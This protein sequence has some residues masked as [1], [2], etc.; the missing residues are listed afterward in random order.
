MLVT[1]ITGSGKSMLLRSLVVQALRHDMQL[2]ISDLDGMTFPIS[3]SHPALL[4]PIAQSSQAAH[5]L[6]QRV[7][8]EVEHRKTLFQAARGA[9]E[10]LDEYNA[11][12]L[13]AG[14]E[15]LKRILLILDE[16]SSTLMEWG[17]VRSSAA[18]ILSQIGQRS[19]KFGVN[20]VFA[21]HEFSAE[22]IGPLRNQCQTIICF[23][24]ISKELA[25]KMGCPG[26]EKIPPGRP[27]LCITNHW[28]PMQAYFA[29]KDLLME[30]GQPIG[31]SLDPDTAR[32]FIA[33]RD[34]QEG[35]VTLTLIQEILHVNKTEAGRLQ[36]S[37]GLRCWLGKDK[38]QKNAF[39]LTDRG[40]ALLPQKLETAETPENSQKQAGN[41]ETDGKE[42]G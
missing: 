41:S 17:G 3:V 4:A 9:P 10:N 34:Q 31:E 26:A 29:D 13:K 38:N 21:A 28:G 35:K 7:L 1:G 36:K 22:Q 20:V 30:G 25:K 42:G 39:V 11:I 33:A 24:T 14:K 6:V 40:L 16:F 27:G 12:A 2:A 19:R 37:W 32:L 23:R 5:E 18:G 8:G 15:P